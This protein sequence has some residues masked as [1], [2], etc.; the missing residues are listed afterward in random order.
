MCLALVTTIFTSAET[1][2]CI[3][4]P[5]RV[6]KTTIV[7]GAALRMYQT[8]DVATSKVLPEKIHAD[9]STSLEYC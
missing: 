9:N 2:N 8:V 3:S 7:H 6:L 1:D 5:E 4:E